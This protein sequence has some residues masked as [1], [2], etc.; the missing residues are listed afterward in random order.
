MSF[1]VNFPAMGLYRNITVSLVMYL[2]I[3][4]TN[5]YG[6]TPPYRKLPVP[7]RP[8][9]PLRSKNWGENENRFY[10]FHGFREKSVSR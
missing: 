3:N 10:G 5:V 6:P 4:I 2:L 7:E 9:P 1:Y 8:E